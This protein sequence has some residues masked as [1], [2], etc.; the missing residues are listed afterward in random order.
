MTREQQ[1]AETFDR[2]RT[3]INR[4]QELMTANPQKRWSV[5]MDLA[6]EFPYSPTYIYNIVKKAK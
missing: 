2:N 5:C 6:K 1:K 4:Y 3:I